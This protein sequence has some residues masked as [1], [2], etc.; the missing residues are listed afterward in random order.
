VTRLIVWRH[1]NTDWNAGNRIQG[2]I[3]T[4]LNDVGRAQAE[5]AAPVLAALRP[6]LIVSS[7]LRRCH[8][9][10]QALAVLTGLEVATDKRLRERY[11]GAWQGLTQAEAADRFPADFVRWKAGEP[12]AEHEPWAEVGGRVAAVLGEVAERLDGGTG[13]VV[14]HGGAIRQGI[15]TLLGWPA[16][17]TRT[18]AGLGNCHWADLRWTP[19]RGWQLH[20]YNVA[21]AGNH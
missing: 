13:V 12:V 20:G 7:D 8:E 1:G 17:V 5:A 9:T 6:A 16:G 19:A 14:C 3:D 15:A 11:F 2:H 21:A 18:V 4:D 10:A